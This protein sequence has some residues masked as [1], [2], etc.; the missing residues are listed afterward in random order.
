M[1]YTVVVRPVRNRL[2][3]SV[4]TASVCVRRPSD[5]VNRES[6]VFL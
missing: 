2:W 3:M 6:D 1:Y 4:R 5:C